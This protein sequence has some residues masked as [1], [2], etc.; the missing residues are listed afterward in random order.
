MEFTQSQ[1]AAYYIKAI[2]GFAGFTP[3]HT[4]MIWTEIPVK[5]LST[6]AGISFFDLPLLFFNKVSH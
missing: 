1:A 2:T 5:T 6:I 4:V 3:D